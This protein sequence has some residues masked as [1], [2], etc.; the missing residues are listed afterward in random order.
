MIVDG[1]ERKMETEK[2]EL[3]QLL[4]RHQMKDRSRYVDANEE[5]YYLNIIVSYLFRDKHSDLGRSTH[6][7]RIKRE[8]NEKNPHFDDLVRY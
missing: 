6:L 5:T 4:W 2:K 1:V 7:L 8:L 3:N